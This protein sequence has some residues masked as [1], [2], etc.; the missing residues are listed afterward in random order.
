MQITILHGGEERKVGEKAGSGCEGLRFT[1]WA[2]TH[3]NLI[4]F[5]PE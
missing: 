4:P 2:I 1:N 5:S 3:K